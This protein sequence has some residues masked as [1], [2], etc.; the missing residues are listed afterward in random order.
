MISFE[1]K[2]I[3]CENTMYE[4]WNSMIPRSDAKN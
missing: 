2:Y 1:M 3:M 4:M